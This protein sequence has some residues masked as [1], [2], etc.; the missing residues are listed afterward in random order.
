MWIYVNKPKTVE[1]IKN[2]IQA[3]IRGLN[4]GTLSKFMQSAWIR[5]HL[6]I[7]ENGNHLQDMIIHK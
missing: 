4:I 6:Y 5:V 2:N 7:H 1:Q 3:D